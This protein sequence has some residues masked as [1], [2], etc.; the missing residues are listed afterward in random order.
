MR[1]TIFSALCINLHLLSGCAFTLPS[2]P[3]C[4]R[5]AS[6]II[7]RSTVDASPP[8]ETSTPA[9]AVVPAE[10]EAS[11]AT[12]TSA[13]T[14]EASSSTEPAAPD[15]NKNKPNWEVNQHRYG[16]GVAGEESLPMP[17][18]YITCGQ[19][20]ALFAITEAD[21]GNMGKGCRVKCSVC[22]NSWYQS[23]ER[24][25]DIPKESHDI[26]PAQ[27]S[28]LD[29]IARNLA[30][31]IPPGFMGVGKLYVGNLEFRTT[32]EELLEFF[33]KNSDGE[34]SVCDV[35]VVKGPDGRSRGFAFVSFYVEADGK[36]ALACNEKE[37]NGRELSVREP[38]N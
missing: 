36:K 31:D 2:Q 17:D 25:F 5:T 11:P 27:K 33:E 8:S 30:R 23:R 32:P 7:V 28:D 24:I 38:N 37:C 21:L 34:V 13:P 18:T 35:S 4:R 19:C 10:A 12:E 3:T 29:R 6:P 14:A 26:L 16:A 22:N 20:K 15:K 9:A 1:T